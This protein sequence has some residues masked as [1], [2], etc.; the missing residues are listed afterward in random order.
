MFNRSINLNAEEE[1]AIRA[2]PMRVKM[3]SGRQDIIRERDR[4]PRCCVVLEGYACTY[5][6]VR[7][8]QRQILS[9]H[10]PGDMPDLHSLH[11]GASSDNIGSIGARRSAVKNKLE[12]DA[13][14]VDAGRARVLTPITALTP[15]FL[16]GSFCTT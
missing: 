3:L 14:H 9:F 13:P 15:R 11:L 12:E 7:D 6:D 8:G 16:G 5:R 2:L 1:G 10:I 4:P